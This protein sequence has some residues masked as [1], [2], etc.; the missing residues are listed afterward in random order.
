VYNINIIL[1]TDRQTDLA[2]RK[3]SNGHHVFATGY[4]IHFLFASRVGFSGTA[5]PV[6]TLQLTSRKVRLY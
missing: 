6:F 2:S 5:D 3:I 4:P 1:M